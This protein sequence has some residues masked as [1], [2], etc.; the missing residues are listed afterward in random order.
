MPNSQA[1][2]GKIGTFAIFDD[3]EEAK[4]Y[5]SIPSNSQIDE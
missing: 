2:G 4:E 1:D 3:A 5:I